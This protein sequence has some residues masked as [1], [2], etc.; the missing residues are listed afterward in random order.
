MSESPMH[1]VSPWPGDQQ[2]DPFVPEGTK[3]V[4][5]VP[6]ATMVTLKKYSTMGLWE[7]RMNYKRFSFKIFF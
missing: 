5:A 4:Q 2:H 3:V 6:T 7:L 1:H